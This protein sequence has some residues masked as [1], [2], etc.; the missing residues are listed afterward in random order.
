M[1]VK[2]RVFMYGVPIDVPNPS[3]RYIAGLYRQ[4][5]FFH[6]QRSLQT[7]GDIES[8]ALIESAEPEGHLTNKQ[9]RLPA[10]CM[11]GG[12]KR[13][14]SAAVRI[15]PGDLFRC[16]G[17]PTGTR[18]ASIPMTLP[19]FKQCPVYRLNTPDLHF[20][21]QLS[22]LVSLRK[23]HI[24]TTRAH[25]HTHTHTHKVVKKKPSTESGHASVFQPELY[26]YHKGTPYLSRYSVEP[27]I[28]RG[29][30]HATVT[31]ELVGPLGRGRMGNAQVKSGSRQSKKREKKKKKRRRSKRFVLGANIGTARTIHSYYLFVC[32]PNKHNVPSSESRTNTPC[33]GRENRKFPKNNQLTPLTPSAQKLP[34]AARLFPRL[35][36][37]TV[38]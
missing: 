26:E 16:Y 38:P 22:P 4:Y 6:F 12:R 14:L 8:R 24:H 27:E 31:V 28:I 37:K 7:L 35:L 13:G 5:R 36:L 33:H 19:G 23:P 11:R 29:D 1:P 34:L 17:E 25:T 10:V 2:R 3:T 15:W 32:R 20:P 9:K 30:M 18:Q 21:P